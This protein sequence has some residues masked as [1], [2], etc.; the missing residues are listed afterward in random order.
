MKTPTNKR[1][2]FRIENPAL[3]TITEWDPYLEL[4]LKKSRIRSHAGSLKN[5]SA[6]GVLIETPHFYPPDTV[7][8]LEIQIPWKTVSFVSLFDREQHEK[9]TG[10]S[11]V[12][13]VVRTEKISPDRYEI[14][15]EF[16]GMDSATVEHISDYL[17][18]QFH[19]IRKER[20]P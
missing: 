10:L 12:A 14:G 15:L 1:R 3:V 9:E 8:K 11:A 19:R 17:L 16:L 20:K 13:K 5:I 6:C 4:K 7:V 18:K 2:Y